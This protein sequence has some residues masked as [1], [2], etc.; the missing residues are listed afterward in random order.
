MNDN[1]N[2]IK[3]LYLNFNCYTWLQ[4]WYVYKNVFILKKN[5]MTSHLKFDL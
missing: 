1:N 3:I 5:R 2:S 4:M